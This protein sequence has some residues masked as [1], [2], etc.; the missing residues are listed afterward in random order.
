MSFLR[1]L[2][3]D[4]VLYGMSTIV[5]RLLNWLMVAVHTRAFNQPEMLAENGLFYTYMIPLNILFTFGMETAFFRYA[6]QKENQ[7]EYFNLILSFILVFGST[8]AGLLILFATP[9]A[10]ALNFPDSE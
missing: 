7:S 4:A 10:G 9:L 8:F 1:K 3:G 6:S 5:G 2:A